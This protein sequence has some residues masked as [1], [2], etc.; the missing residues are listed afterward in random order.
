[1]YRV[2]SCN[3]IRTLFFKY[4]LLSFI[5]NRE[6]RRTSC[7]MAFLVHITLSNDILWTDFV[8]FSHHR[9]DF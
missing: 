2:M 4:I 9:G 3:S 5:N 8:E 1:M 7:L 6:H